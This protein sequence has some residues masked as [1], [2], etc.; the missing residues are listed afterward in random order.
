MSDSS[1]DNSPS[2]PSLTGWARRGIVLEP[3][4]VSAFVKRAMI[5]LATKK[6]HAP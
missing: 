6:T 3:L 5:N 4:R 2:E 1:L